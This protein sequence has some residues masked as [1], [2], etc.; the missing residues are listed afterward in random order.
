MLFIDAGQSAQ[1]STTRV[2]HIPMLTFRSL[3]VTVAKTKTRQVRKDPP[4]AHH[5]SGPRVMPL[6][7]TTLSSRL[8]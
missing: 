6:E 3:D 7:L 4:R 1:Q 5:R 8:V 2:H